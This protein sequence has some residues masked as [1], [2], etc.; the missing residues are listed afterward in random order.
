MRSR[1]LGETTGR[2][3]VAGDLRVVL[4]QLSRRLREQGPVGD[5]TRSQS[6]VLAR[7]EREGPATMSALAQAEGMRPQSMGAIVA[8][9]EA[10]GF[11][12]RAP[13]PHDGRKVLVA[14]TD[15]AREQ[16]ASGRLAR[17]D[18]LFRAIRTELTPA[19]QEQLGACVELLQRLTRCP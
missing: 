15:T 8:V 13:D 4:G 12:C 3:T 9:L 10:A 2:V 16:F 19:E 5:L 14:L 7:L 18:W 1:T 6:A 17:E 11:A